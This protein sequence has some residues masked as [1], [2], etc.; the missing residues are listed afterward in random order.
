ML[1]YII[2][3]VMVVAMIVI[4]T[5]YDQI[6]T[7][8]RT[9]GFQND[10]YKFVIKESNIEGFAAFSLQNIPKDTIFLAV[11]DFDI[12]KVVNNKDY[13]TAMNDKDFVCPTDYD[14]E[15][16]LDTFRTY[17]DKESNSDCNAVVYKIVLEIDIVDH[18]GR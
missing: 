4:Y 14:L 2:V 15:K 7:S 6:M 8:V 16:I 10:K 17:C 12:D 1:T 9:I 13:L 5:Y 11:D 18:Q 3:I